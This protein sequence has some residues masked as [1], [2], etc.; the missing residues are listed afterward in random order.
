MSKSYCSLLYHIVF[1]TK[2]REP[3]LEGEMATRCHQYLG[4][5]VRDEGGRA[6][7]VNGTADHVHILAALRQDKAVSNVIRGIKSNSSGWFHRTFRR[8]AFHWQVGYGAFTVSQ[9]KMESVRGYI[10]RQQEHHH[11]TTFCDEF[12]ALLDKHGV[13]YDPEHIWQ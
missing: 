7:V 12:V 9:S 6:L 13:E 11:R 8:T 10:V 3:W 5:A 1:S 2:N 4:G